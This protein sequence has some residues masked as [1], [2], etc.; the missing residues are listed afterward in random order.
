MNTLRIAPGS[1]NRSEI[2][3]E[4]HSNTRDDSKVQKPD[5]YYRD[6]EKLEDWFYQI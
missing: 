3:D 5:L 2:S 1:I 4:R 6:R